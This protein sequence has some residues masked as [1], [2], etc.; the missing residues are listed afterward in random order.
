MNIV[1]TI[2]TA[3]LALHAVDLNKIPDTCINMKYNQHVIALAQKATG[4]HDQQ[5]HEYSNLLQV[6]KNILKCKNKLSNND[7]EHLSRIEACK[8]PNIK[9]VDCSR[10][11]HCPEIV[12]YFESMQY[13]EHND[14]TIMEEKLQKNLYDQ[15]DRYQ[16]NQLQYTQPPVY[17]TY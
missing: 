4:Y 5:S 9:S 15:S 6:K 10:I 2:Y 12:E 13:Q 1:A 17:K 3:L 11:M 14:G 7:P 8:A 16:C